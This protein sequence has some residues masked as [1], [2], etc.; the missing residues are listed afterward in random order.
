MNNLEILLYV[1]LG[2]AAFAYAYIIVVKPQKGSPLI[3]PSK[4]V[5]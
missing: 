5:G 3:P 1:V 2:V 4:V